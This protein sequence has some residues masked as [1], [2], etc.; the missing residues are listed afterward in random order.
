[1][2]GPQGRQIGRRLHHDLRRQQVPHQDLGRGQELGHQPSGRRR[3]SLEATAAGTPASPPAPPS[4]PCRC[5]ACWTTSQL[6]PTRFGVYLGSGEGNQDFDCFLADDD[7]GSDARGRRSGEVH[8][9]R[10]W[11]RSTRVHEI[12]QE[13]NMPAGHLAGMFNAQGPNANCLTACAAS[14]Q[15]IGEATEIIRR[16]DAD[17]ML[18]GGAHS[19]IHPFGVTG[20]NLLTALSTSND[21]PTQGLAPVRP[22]P[23]RLR[24]RR[25]RRDGRPRRTRARQAPRRA[26]L[27]R[28]PRLRHDGRRLPHHRHPSR[29]PRR[30]RLHADGDRRRRT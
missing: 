19:M 21:E 3:A 15:A 5:R 4:R 24:A 25:R 16:G 20:F 17:V 13:P 26:D 27:R 7:R 18:S 14:S 9:R 30:D 8:A 1:M 6:D 10:A 23:R 12:E 2:V 28:G 22:P 29:R 11:K